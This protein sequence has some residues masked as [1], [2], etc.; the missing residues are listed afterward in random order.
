MKQTYHSMKGDELT[1]DH[2][3]WIH[4]FVKGHWMSYLK[5]YKLAVVISFNSSFPLTK[6]LQPMHDTN[7]CYK[8]MVS[9]FML[10]CKRL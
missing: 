8:F 3:E 6:N 5:S 2:G 9:A 7:I 4:Y 1:T 10:W